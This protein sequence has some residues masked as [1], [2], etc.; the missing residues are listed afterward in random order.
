LIGNRLA[1]PWNANGSGTPGNVPSGTG[2]IVPTLRIFIFEVGWSLSGATLLQRVD[3]VAHHPA[4]IN[5]SGGHPPW[6]CLKK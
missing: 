6:T 1:G 2:R 3:L 5:R 4:Q